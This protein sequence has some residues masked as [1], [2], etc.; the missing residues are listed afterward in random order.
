MPA[1]SHASM[2]CLVVVGNSPPSSD[3]EIA[4]QPAP[5]QSFG[6]D[7]HGWEREPAEEG[8]GTGGIGQGWAST[9][10]WVALTPWFIIVSASF[11]MRDSFHL[12]RG[13]LLRSCLDADVDVPG[14]NEG[15]QAK[16]NPSFLELSID[17]FVDG[18]PRMVNSSSAAVNM[19]AEV[20][21]LTQCVPKMPAILIS[22]AF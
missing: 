11:S 17:F 14:Q 22:Y 5:L 21:F 12:T 19:H 8:D 18:E 3:Q 15:A 4:G 9:Q 10:C 1:T 6:D 2:R 20:D 7:G 16:L 13:H